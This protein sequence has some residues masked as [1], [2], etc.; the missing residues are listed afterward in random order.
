MNWGLQGERVPPAKRKQILSVM[1]QPGA[2]GGAR[3]GL[4]KAGDR[5][6]AVIRCV[7]GAGPV[8]AGQPDAA[9]G[10]GGGRAGGRAVP[11]QHARA[12]F[13]PEA[14]VKRLVVADETGG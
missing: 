11:C 3:R 12:G 14:V 4:L 8:V 1:L 13:G 7:V 10:R 6:G 9:E 2:D 5:V